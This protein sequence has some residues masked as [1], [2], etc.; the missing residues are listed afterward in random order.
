VQQSGAFSSA[1]SVAIDSSEN[2]FVGGSYS[3]SV[4][5][6]PGSGTFMLPTVGRS[7]I[8]KLN[9][10]G[11]LVWARALESDTSMTVYGLAVDAAGAIYATGAFHGTVD[12]DPGAGTYSRTTAGKGDAYVVKLTSAGDFSWAETFGAAEDDYGFGITV[13]T[14]GAVRIGGSFRGTVDFDP[15]PLA[16]H[17]LTGSETLQNGY[18]LKL[19]QS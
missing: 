7:Y 3:G 10:S 1:N 6:K 9:S 18:L 4:D 8:T 16:T 17:L 12:F 15:D 14:T 19:L 11:G 13:D 5:F 2:V